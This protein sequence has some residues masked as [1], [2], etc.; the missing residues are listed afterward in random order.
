MAIKNHFD[1]CPY[2]C[3]NEGKVL[4]PTR[5]AMVPC[6]HC[7]A[8]K[9]DLLS[10][11]LAVEEYT[12][13]PVS[14]SSLLGVNSKYLT[15]VF[16]Y[17]SVIPE[18]E[19]VFLEDNS[20]QTQK[21]EAEELYHQLVLGAKPDKSYCFGISIKGRLDRFAYPMLAKAY[22]SGLS[23]AKCVSCSDYSR[24]QLRMNDDLDDYLNSDIAIVVINDGCTNGDLAVVKGL[25]QS[26]ALRGNPTI[27]LSTWT[28]EACSGLLSSRS[29][30]SS[31]FMA[32]PSFVSYKGSSSKR[33]SYINGLL[34]VANS[35][36]VKTEGP[37]VSISSL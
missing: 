35:Y 33:S 12:E 15:E 7:S 26:R 4:D 34:G 5:G 20:Y 1:D 2:G 8:I 23:V 36:S 9:K 18:S 28:I 29:D 10:K 13:V 24:L 22:M 6:P 32:Y 19:R 17:D 25:M 16:V 11:G 27:F 37:G 21:K 14:L 3:N 31:M 30:E